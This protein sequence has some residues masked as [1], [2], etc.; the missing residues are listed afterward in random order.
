MRSLQYNYSFNDDD[1]EPIRFEKI[2]EKTP[3]DE[4]R[5]SGKKKSKSFIRIKDGEQE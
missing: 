2:K 4:F 5:K 1:F 3:K